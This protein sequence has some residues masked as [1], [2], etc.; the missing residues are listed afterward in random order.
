MIQENQPDIPWRGPILESDISTLRSYM[1]YIDAPEVAIAKKLIDEGA[2]I[3]SYYLQLSSPGD[4]AAEIH[5]ARQIFRGYTMVSAVILEP[6]SQKVHREEMDLFRVIEVNGATVN[7]QVSKPDQTLTEIYQD[8]QDVPEEMVNAV[9]EEIKSVVSPHLVDPTLFEGL[10]VFETFPR[11]G[12]DLDLIYGA[13]DHSRERFL[14][15]WLELHK[16]DTSPL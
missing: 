12:S 2:E 5:R 15:Y 8:F 3:A 6:E 14:D 13:V 16:Q 7:L 9:V 1:K 11:R 4:I 10:D